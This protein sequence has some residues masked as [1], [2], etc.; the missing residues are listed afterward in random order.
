[1]TKTAKHNLFLLRV[2]FLSL[3]II[4]QLSAFGQS[5]PLASTPS[6]DTSSTLGQYTLVWH[7]EF[8]EKTLDTTNWSY[9][10]NGN[11]GGNNELQYYTDSPENCFLRD[12]ALVIQ[13]LKKSH[14]G[15]SY[16]S[17]RI[18]TQKKFS[19]KYGRVEV[20]AKVP[21]GKGIWPAIWMLG[22]DISRV[23]W[24]ACGEIDMMEYAGK[25]PHVIHGSIHTTSSHGNT[26]NTRILDVPTAETAFHNYAI[27]WD[28]KKIDFFVD[29]S[30]YYT[31]KPDNYNDNTWPFNKDF[32]LILNV[33]VGGN[34]G[35][36]VDDNIFPQTMEVKSVRVY[37]KTTL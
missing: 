30:L 13:A 6:K 14:K 2:G 27:E 8:N 4:G 24:P 18:R 16:T 31:Y 25:E 11:G 12:G 26:V 22:S 1:M 10:V 15:K 7:D 9:E 28:T 29:D 21:G 19:F 36:A 5:H 35:G 32:F 23:G 33:A 3:I 17:A 37:Q 34:F 20:V